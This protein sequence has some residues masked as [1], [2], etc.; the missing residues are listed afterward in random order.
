MAPREVVRVV[1]RS[2]AG[3]ST[4]LRALARLTP[5][6]AGELRLDGVAAR[7]IPAPRWRRR[8]AYLAQSPPSLPGSVWQNLE[9]AFGC[10]LARARREQLDRDVARA[11]AAELLLDLDALGEREAARLSG[12]ELSR[13]SLLRAL[14]IKPDVLLAD[15]PSAA[16][17]AESA[18][19]LA[20][21]LS[22]Y[23]DDGGAL[24]LVAH[25]GARWAALAPREVT[26]EEQQ[27]SR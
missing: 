21:R 12:G 22:R 3:K 16:L 7:E 14:L 6:R 13:L 11:Q 2:G 17:D 9:A 5:L 15:E 18:A 24:V 8:V 27:G 4:L 1:G 19:A 10:Q 26:L 20:T 23:V 25:D